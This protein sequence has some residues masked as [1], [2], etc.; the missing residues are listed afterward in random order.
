[1][2]SFIRFFTVIPEGTLTAT[3]FDPLGTI[4]GSSGPQILVNG[5]NG[6]G[7][8]NSSGLLEFPSGI[9]GEFAIGVTVQGLG[10]IDLKS[11]RLSFGD[12]LGRTVFT[13]QTIALLNTHP[14]IV[15]VPLPDMFWPTAIGL[16][17]LMGF[18]AWRQ[19][20]AT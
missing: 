9:T 16:V 17:G 6:I 10:E 12:A 5:L 3:V 19:R 14:D 18:V 11:V 2:S 1:M 15:T 13:A 7:F 4:L 8:G 20:R